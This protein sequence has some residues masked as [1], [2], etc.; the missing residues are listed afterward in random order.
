MFLLTL[1]KALKSIGSFAIAG[2]GTGL[3][4]ATFRSPE[5]PLCWNSGF[6]PL[7]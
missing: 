7:A 4:G 2:G 5:A 6:A 3:A 1:I